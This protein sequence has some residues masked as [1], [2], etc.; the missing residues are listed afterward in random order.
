MCRNRGDGRP[1]MQGCRAHSHPISSFTRI[2][3]DM[4]LPS[5]RNPP[6]RGRE[7]WG[8]PG[9]AEGVALLSETGLAQPRDRGCTLR[10]RGTSPPVSLSFHE[11]AVLCSLVWGKVSPPIDK[12]R[13]TG[14]ILSWRV[15]DA[16]SLLGKRRLSIVATGEGGRGCRGGRGG[17]GP[18]WSDD[19]S[20][21][22]EEESSWRLDKGAGRPTHT[23]IPGWQLA[24]STFP[25]DLS[26]FRPCASKTFR[27]RQKHEM[28]RGF[29]LVEGNAVRPPFLSL[30]SS[31][32]IGDYNINQN[33]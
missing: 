13:D 7:W 9:R 2:S 24:R 21:R 32:F 1:G 18:Q 28:L 25:L 12:G 30:R 5:L 17:G 10:V 19:G 31:W 14:E 29:L 20:L 11:S 27:G 8:D 16:E 4:K 22:R 6:A 15:S 33:G 3:T 26:N 23:G